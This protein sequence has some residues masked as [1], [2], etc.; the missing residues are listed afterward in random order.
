M[1]YG[2]DR[3]IVR[4]IVKLTVPFGTIKFSQEN[5]DIQQ[6]LDAWQPE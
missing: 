2:P 5:R 1:R 3:F 4:T 6:K